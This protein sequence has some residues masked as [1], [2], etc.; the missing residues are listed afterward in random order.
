MRIHAYNCVSMHVHLHVSVNL[1]LPPPPRLIAF[2]KSTWFSASL[3]LEP[4]TQQMFHWKGHECLII[5]V[6]DAAFLFV[7]VQVWATVGVLY[8]YFC[9]VCI[10]LCVCVCGKEKDLINPKTSVFLFMGVEK[11]NFF[12]LHI[13]CLAMNEQWSLLEMLFRMISGCAVSNITSVN[14]YKTRQSFFSLFVKQKVK[15]CFSP[16]MDEQTGLSL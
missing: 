10:R 7:S 1:K 5:C 12:L 15:P 9:M 4:H 16:I 14:S 2:L 8:V 6:I 11:N 13:S 3:R